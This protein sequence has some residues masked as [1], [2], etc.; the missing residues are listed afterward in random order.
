M[1]ARFP[2]HRQETLG[3]GV[4]SLKAGHSGG[5]FSERFIQ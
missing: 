2:L 3:Q 5:E 1:L 4:F